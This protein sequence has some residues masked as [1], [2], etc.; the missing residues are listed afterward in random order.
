LNPTPVG[1]AFQ[2]DSVCKGQCPAQTL[3]VG[4]G[5]EMMRDEGV[6]VVIARALRAERLGEGVRVVELGTNGFDVIYEMEGAARVIVTDA[7]KAG[8]DPGTIYTFTP[9]DAR[10]TKSRTSSLHGL[11]LLDVLELAA[12]TSIRPPVM[13]IGV[14]PEEV[15]PGTGLSLTVGR[16]VGETVAAVKRLI[17]DHAAWPRTGGEH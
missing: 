6:G 8:R 4:L 14:E 15:A 5:N 9:E 7:V 13:I 3:V 12:L 2:P 11:D 16:R 10:N 17:Q 1:R